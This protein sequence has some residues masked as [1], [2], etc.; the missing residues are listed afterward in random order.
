MTITVKLDEPFNAFV[1]VTAPNAV[2]DYVVNNLPEWAGDWF[3]VRGVVGGAGR[4]RRDGDDVK[5]Y[6]DWLPRE[7]LAERVKRLRKERGL[8]MD[9]IVVITGLSTMTL[10]YLERGQDVR[11]GTLNK[12]AKALGISVIDMLTDVNL[13]NLGEFHR[14]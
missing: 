12:I 10:S 9:K 14:P 2:L 1:I 5:E 11:L 8:T 6:T 3:E 13:D 4:R 7:T